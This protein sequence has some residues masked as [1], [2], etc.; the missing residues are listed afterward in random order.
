MEILGFLITGPAPAMREA[1]SPSTRR[2]AGA[3]QD[4]WTPPGPAAPTEVQDIV[5]SFLRLREPGL[6]QV[7]VE[8]MRSLERCQQSGSD[9]R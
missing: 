1:I 7:A 5:H 2:A 4:G 6:R 3:L 8:L 9:W